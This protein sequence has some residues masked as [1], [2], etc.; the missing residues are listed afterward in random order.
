MTE[1]LL[2]PSKITAYLDCAHYLTLRHRLEAGHLTVEGR[3]GSMARMLQ[4]KG[5][6]HEQACLADYSERGKSVFE[7]PSKED[8]ESFARWV[9]RIGNP[10]DSAADV[11]YQMPF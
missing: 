9:A 4:E 11:I 10:M 2:T 7:V 8:G 5:L 6:E 3:F 1:R